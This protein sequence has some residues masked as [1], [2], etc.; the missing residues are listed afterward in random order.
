MNTYWVWGDIDNIDEC[1]KLGYNKIKIT[2][3]FYSTSKKS[4]ISGYVDINGCISTSSSADNAIK[5][6]VEESGE[7]KKISGSVTTD[8]SDFQNSKKIY[9]ILGNENLSYGFSVDNLVITYTIY[10]E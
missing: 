6:F 3:S 1:I 8:L 9:M 7:N 5:S 2:Y 10:K 4:L